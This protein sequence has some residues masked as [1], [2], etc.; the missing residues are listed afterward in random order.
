MAVGEANLWREGGR[1][2]GDFG[3][4]QTLHT[5]RHAL[6]EMHVH[7]TAAVCMHACMSM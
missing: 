6:A 1:G 7:C 3:V 5:R 4:M 2:G